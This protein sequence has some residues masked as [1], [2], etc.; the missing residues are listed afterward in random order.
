MLVTKTGIRRHGVN[1]HNYRSLVWL[2]RPANIA[3]KLTDQAN[4]PAITRTLSALNVGYMIGTQWV[5]QME[6]GHQFVENLNSGVF[7]QLTHKDSRF[8]SFFPINYEY[9]ERARTPPILM[10]Q[11]VFEGFKTANPDAKSIKEGWF[12][13]IDFHIDEYKGE[14]FGGDVI[15]TQMRD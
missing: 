13:K 14:I 11:S 2:G 12:K 6:F 4:K 8:Q 10:T 3:S 1:Q 7:G 5:W 9:T 15:W